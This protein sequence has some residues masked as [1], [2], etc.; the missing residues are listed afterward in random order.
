MYPAK[1][2]PRLLRSVRENIQ[3]RVEL[4]QGFI[5]KNTW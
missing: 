1:R 2:D 3:K 5:L 4:I